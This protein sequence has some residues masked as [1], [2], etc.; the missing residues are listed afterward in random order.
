[1][2]SVKKVAMLIV[3]LVMTF[4]SQSVFAAEGQIEDMP[5]GWAKEAVQNAVDRGLLTPYGGKV[6]PDR[7]LTRAE[8][9]AVVNRL[10]GAEAKAGLNSF[11]DIPAVSWYADDMAKAVQMKFFQGS[12]GKLTP[13]KNITRQEAFVALSRILELPKGDESQ[14]K[15]FQD[16][17]S[18]AAWAKES[19]AAMVDAGFVT[20]SNGRLRPSEMITRAEFAQLMYQIADDRIDKHGEYSQ[21]YNGNLFVSVPEVTLKNSVIAGDLILCDGIGT[22]DIKLDHVTVEGRIVVRGGG[23]DTVELIASK[24]KGDMVIN[25]VNNPVHILASGGTALNTVIVQNRAILDAPISLLSLNGEAD[26][27]I[28]SGIVTSMEVKAEAEG[29][30]VTVES[31]AS[32]GSAV[33]KAEN[34]LLQGKGQITQVQ[35]RGN[36]LIV[37]T[38]GT[39]VIV[40]QGIK[41]VKAGGVDIAGG[42]SA[43]IDKSGIGAV[44]SGNVS[45]TGSGGSK[46]S[47]GSGEPKP[48]PGT[49]PTDK[50]WVEVSKTGI[51]HVEPVSYATVAL[52]LET[53]STGLPS[54]YEYYIEGAKQSS[55]NISTVMK[56]ADGSILVIKIML[57]N[58]ADSQTLKLVKGTEHMLIKLNDIGHS[59]KE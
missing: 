8:I 54:E 16:G 6:Y 19:T 30:S 20:G 9:A 53:M 28:Q 25:N 22:G 51:I 12:G 40:D 41:G 15:V 50:N 36:N 42:K 5:V 45:G 38:S 33:I 48:D 23:K 55:S 14:L 4:C 7:A 11:T 3:I 10:F 31:G 35:A 18:V 49:K 2:S 52:R 57:S 59:K 37:N 1:M 39:K 29:S 44:V 27:T 26:V 46:G 56:S 58:N 43:L 17:D 24:I 32:I 21:N 13:E 47:G 34:T